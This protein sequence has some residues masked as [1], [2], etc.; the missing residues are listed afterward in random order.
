VQKARDA[1]ESQFSAL[2]AQALITY[3]H[4]MYLDKAANIPAAEHQVCARAAS[5]FP[6]A[7][8]PATA[9]ARADYGRARRPSP[10]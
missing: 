10:P 8:L 1:I 7:R 6:P 9:P 5:P 3:T 4:E 2:W